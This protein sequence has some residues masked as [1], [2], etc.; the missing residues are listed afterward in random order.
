MKSAKAAI[1]LALGRGGDQALIK[2]GD[3]YI[4]YGGK[5][6]EV[7]HNA[8][9][10]ARVKAD[11]LSELIAESERVYVICLLYTSPSPRDA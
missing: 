1:D 5:S 4:F 7:S 6:G 9:I 3:K 8:R 11:A 10:R 2:N